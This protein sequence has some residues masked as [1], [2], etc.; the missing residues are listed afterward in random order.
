MLKR[1]YLFLLLNV[2]SINFAFAGL[3]IEITEGVED[4]LPI[5]IVPFKW[6]G[7]GQP[8]E[9]IAGIVAADLKRSGQFAPLSEKDM[10]A[11]PSSPREVHFKNWRMLDIPNLVIGKIGPAA[12]NA[13]TIEFRLF[14]VYR[15]RQMTGFKYR[16]LPDQLRKIAH[17]VSDVV[18][19]E[20]TGVKGAF[21]TQIVYIKKFSNKTPKPYRL[22]LSDS[23]TFNEQ[24]IMRHYMPLF[25]PTW[26]PDNKT[27]AFAMAGSYGQGIFLFDINKG[28]APRRLT[29]RSMKASAPSW[30]PDGKKLAMQVLSNGSADIYVMDIATKKT[31]RITRH[32]SIDAEPAWSPDGKSLVFTSERGGAPQL[33]QYFFDTQKVRRLTFK[34]KN[35]LRA[36][37]SPDGKMITFVH[38]SENNGYNIAVMDLDTL[39]M[40]IVADSGKGESEHESPSFAPNGS[41][42]IYAAN[43]PQKGKRGRKTGL[44]AVSVDGK[45]RQHF[46]DEGEGEVREPAWSSFLN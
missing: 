18:F 38:L 41:M 10:L 14:D 13:Y 19:E 35:N 3:T 23:D 40:R 9:D 20:L 1:V 24:E 33:Y 4:A 17:K 43:Y 16:A 25:S 32:W 27:I 28:T 34:G 22:Y 37:F 6:T 11:K 42:I 2:L 5:A 15:Q 21:D 26:S 39:E 29:P 36:S 12:N 30:S 44:V 31:K 45:I 7:E 46:V 8:P